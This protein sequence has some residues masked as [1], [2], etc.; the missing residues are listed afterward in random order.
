MKTNRGL[1][2]NQ[3]FFEITVFF[4]VVL[5]VLGSM[6]GCSDRQ[7]SEVD[8]LPDD[9]IIVNTLP[10]IPLGI[11]YEDFSKRLMNVVYINSNTSGELEVHV[12]FESE[13]GFPYG[14]S[15]YK[16]V[17]SDDFLTSIEAILGG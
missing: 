5:F 14:I 16:L 9:A 12:F 17:F 13:N 2:R 8:A 15:G 6:Q 1:P 7:S 11:T 3:K 10:S 4:S